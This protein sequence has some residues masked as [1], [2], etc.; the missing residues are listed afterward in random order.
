MGSRVDPHRDTSQ[1]TE[2]NIIIMGMDGTFFFLFSFFF[3]FPSYGMGTDKWVYCSLSSSRA[4]RKRSWISAF[5]RYEIG[6]IRRKTI[7]FASCYTINVS[8]FAASHSMAYA[9]SDAAM[10]LMWKVVL[11]KTAPNFH[12]HPLLAALETCSPSSS[13]LTESGLRPM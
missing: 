3:L 9:T 8:I 2:Q 11:Y 7:T 1:A 6:L 13:R 10:R 12:M 5:W 4:N